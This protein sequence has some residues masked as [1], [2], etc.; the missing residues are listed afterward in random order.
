MRSRPIGIGDQVV[1]NWLAR[2]A[3]YGDGDGGVVIELWTQDDERDALVASYGRQTWWGV[4]WLDRA[5]DRL[6]LERRS[7]RETHK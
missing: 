2:L 7:A 1:P 4:D 3:N 5:D 6:V